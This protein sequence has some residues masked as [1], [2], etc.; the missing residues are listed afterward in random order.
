[1]LTMAPRLTKYMA[2]IDGV[3]AYLICSAGQVS[4]GGPALDTN[5]ADIRLLA[6]RLEDDYAFYAKVQF[7]SGTVGSPEAGHRS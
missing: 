4:F 5:G 1:M 7:T 3:G 6:F 2:W